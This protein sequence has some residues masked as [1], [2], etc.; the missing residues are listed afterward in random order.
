[1]LPGFLLCLLLT[2]LLFG[3]DFYFKNTP[4]WR[5]LRTTP[6]ELVSSGLFAVAGAIWLFQAT[7]WIYRMIAVTYR[8]TN[9]RL[10]YIRGFKLPECWAIKLEQIADVRVDAGPLERLLGVGRIKILVQNGIS[11]DFVLDGVPAPERVAR[12]IRRRV[13]QAQRSS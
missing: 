7:R 9:R 4:L 2:V 1:M 5:G 13:R 6:Q 3:L 8:L 11:S 10:L 12:T